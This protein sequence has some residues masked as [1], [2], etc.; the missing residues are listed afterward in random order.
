MKNDHDHPD[1]AKDT[2]AAVKKLVA[3]VEK[4]LAD[5]PLPPSAPTVCEDEMTKLREVLKTAPGSGDAADANSALL[6]C[7]SKATNEAKCKGKPQPC[8]VVYY[9]PPIKL[10]GAGQSVSEPSETKAVDISVPDQIAAA[11]KEIAGAGDAGLST[12]AAADGAT[13]VILGSMVGN[14]SCGAWFKAAANNDPII[15]IAPVF[16]PTVQLLRDLKTY[17]NGVV[18]VTPEAVL[19]SS[20][21]RVN[22]TLVTMRIGGT[23]VPVGVLPIVPVEGTSGQALD[24]AQHTV[25]HRVNQVSKAVEDGCKAAGICH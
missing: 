9:N 15:F 6:R 23:L 18:D 24:E 20:V 11:C 17:T 10:S 5:L 1:N 16:A 25:Q 7:T 12:A 19:A 3:A 2:Q 4:S 22:R 8:G 21:E 13:G 14:Y